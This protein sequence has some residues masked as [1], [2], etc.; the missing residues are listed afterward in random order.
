MNGQ[1]NAWR[2]YS[3]RLATDGDG[4]PQLQEISTSPRSDFRDVLPCIRH[5]ADRHSP[6][7]RQ[8]CRFPRHI[9]RH[10]HS[11]SLLLGNGAMPGIHLNNSAKSPCPDGTDIQRHES[12]ALET[13]PVLFS[14]TSSQSNIDMDLFIPDSNMT[15]ENGTD[16][17]EFTILPVPLFLSLQV[18]IWLVWMSARIMNCVR[19]KRRRVNPDSW[20]AADWEVFRAA[21]ARMS[22]EIEKAKA[23]LS[24]D[25]LLSVDNM[26]RESQRHTF[27]E[28]DLTRPRG[29]E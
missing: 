19:V 28:S 2:S 24:P 22:E 7:Y 26:S 4:G 10:W 18:A 8:D 3:T 13:E 9:A 1:V 12:F 11:R 21:Q 25:D 23:E 20:N 14:S 16:G 17:R 5:I 6:L 27:V 15:S 29:T